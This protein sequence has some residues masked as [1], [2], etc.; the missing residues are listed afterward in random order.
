[1]E[2]DVM[3]DAA[4]FLHEPPS[5]KVGYKKILF[6]ANF[7]PN[8]TN[9]LFVFSFLL[10]I[11]EADVKALY[12]MEADVAHDAAELLHEPRPLVH[13]GR[14]AEEVHAVPDDME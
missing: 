11:M 2:A 12:I 3:H 5:E 1:M 13:F 6:I 7:L 10:C 14:L 8:K 4:E 9:L